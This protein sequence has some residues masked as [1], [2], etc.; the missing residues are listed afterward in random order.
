M[1]AFYAKLGT[2]LG[3]KG[4]GR[5]GNAISGSSPET[6]PL[7]YSVKF[8]KDDDGHP[9]L[10]WWLENY[11]DDQGDHANYELPQRLDLAPGFQSP[12]DSGHANP[13]GFYAFKHDGQLKVQ[14]LHFRGQPDGQ[15][16]DPIRDEYT[17][18]SGLY[19]AED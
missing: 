15:R 10:I 4:S 6:S 17:Y 19:L 8:G 12:T 2:S 9:L 1:P 5:W 14:F 11:R 16:D 18:R 7:A 3:Y 13:L